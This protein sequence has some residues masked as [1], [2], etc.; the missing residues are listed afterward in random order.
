MYFILH[1]LLPDL[2]ANIQAHKSRHSRSIFLIFLSGMI[3]TDQPEGRNPFRLK[4]QRLFTH[5]HRPAVLI[6][7]FLTEL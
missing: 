4:C 6:F 1:H 5:P 2:L 3:Q 7:F